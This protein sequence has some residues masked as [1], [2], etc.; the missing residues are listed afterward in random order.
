MKSD[1]DP[2]K[3]VVALTT[4]EKSIIAIAR[5]LA[6]QT[7]ILILDESTATLSKTDVNKLFGVLRN[8]AEHGISIFI[9]I[10]SLR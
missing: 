3:L 6:L 10:T 4:A 7:K 8:L 1:I 2:T 9:Y 5:A